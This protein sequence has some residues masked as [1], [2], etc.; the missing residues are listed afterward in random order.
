M[1]NSTNPVLPPTAAGQLDWKKVAT[2]QVYGAPFTCE[3]QLL[4][5]RVKTRLKDTLQGSV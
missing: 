5:H 3:V 2:Q 4:I 1:H